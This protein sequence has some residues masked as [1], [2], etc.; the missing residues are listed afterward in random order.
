MAH[1]QEGG[2]QCFIHVMV[3]L[4]AANKASRSQVNFKLAVRFFSAA[5]VCYIF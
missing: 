1:M 3:H 5:K 2:G 4:Q